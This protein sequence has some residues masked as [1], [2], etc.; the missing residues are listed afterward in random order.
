MKEKSLERKIKKLEEENMGLKRKLEED[1]LAMLNIIEDLRESEERYKKLF[2]QSPIAITV[3]EEDGTVS[4]ANENFAKLTGYS[5]DE[6]IGQHFTK[7]VAEEDRERMMKYH[8]QRITGKGKPPTRYEY[9]CLRK[10]GEMRDVELSIIKLPGNR[11]LSCKIDITER[12]KMEEELRKSEEKYRLVTENSQDI[13]YAIDKNYELLFVTGD[14]EGITGY[15]LKDLP[16]GDLKKAIFA[17]PPEDIKVIGEL[18]ERVWKGEKNVKGEFRIIRK[19]GKVRWVE[20]SLSPLYDEK[21]KVYGN[22]GILRDITERKKLEEE[23]RKSE[24]KYRT[25]VETSSDGIISIDEEGKIIFWNKAAGEIFGYSQKEVIGKPVTMLMPRGYK[26]KHKKAFKEFLERA[27]KLKRTL[28]VEG[29]RKNGEI[30]P[31]EFSFSAYKSDHVFTFIA[32]ARDITE[33]KKMEEKIR[34]SEEHLR[35]IF[36]AS[37]EIIFTKNLESRYTHANAAFSRI[38]KRPLEE[39]VG[40]T[41]EEI[42]PREEAKMLREID[43]EVLEKGK[44]E[45]HEDI[46]TVAGEKRIFQTTKVPLRNEEGKVVGLCGFAKD[47]TERKKMEE[48]LKESEEKYR[49]FVENANDGICII[50]DGAVKFANSRLLQMGGYSEEDVINQPFSKFIAEESLDEVMERY[51]RR[52]AGEKV[53]SIYETMLKRKDGG[54]IFAEFNV[55]IIDYEGG[56]AELVIVRDITERKK[57]E[58]ALKESEEK[59]RGLVENAHDAIYIITP[60]GFQYV[61]PAFEELTGYSSKE[62]LSKEFSF[63]NLIHPDDIKFIE[64]REKARIKGKE[65]PSRYEFRIISKDGK[66]KT[67]EVATVDIGKR[68]EVRIM[69]I[70]RDVTERKKAEEEIEKLS[71]LHYIIGMSINGSKTIKELCSNLIKNVKEII[72]VEYANIFVYN[73]SKKSLEPIAHVGYPKE[74]AKRIVK[75][76]EVNEEQPWEAVKACLTKKEKYIKD[77]QIYKPLSFHWDLYK[78]YDIRELYTIPLVIK[79][80][81]EGVLQVSTTSK[82]PLAEKKRLLKSIA[83]EIAAGMAKIKAEEEMMRA[84]KQEREFKLKTAHYFLNPIAIAK[85]YLDLAM[86]ELP[87]EKRKKL[88]SAKYAIGRVEKVV[89]NVTQRGEIR[90]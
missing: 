18:S 70:L 47:I 68:G 6:M 31:V 83:E 56:K 15:T 71:E 87:E 65:I 38:F 26:E 33:R 72:G 74:L 9:K 32:I 64:Q 89:K 76:Y 11:T 53:E 46:L 80:K 5:L 34:E 90:E 86:E 24:E 48:A 4:M 63:W 59:F 1:R 19:D 12:K 67:V 36:N 58:E 50:K 8:E 10:D 73:R 88:E 49:T 27:E 79:G 2:E 17:V 23:L 43:L 20:V 78:K 25:L 3:I 30:F 40:K 54:I 29:L 37:E 16:D 84:L 21:G 22:Q 28:E 45:K 35:G 51:R 61:N 41:D 14:I 85:G 39:I 44:I 77:V 62:I 13:I 55:S 81:V 69:G 82:N 66:V 57:M 75:R 60:E 7:F 52:M 42:F